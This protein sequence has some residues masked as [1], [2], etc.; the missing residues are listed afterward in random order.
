[1]RN[2][3]RWV[4]EETFRTI[5]EHAPIVSV[6]L[7]VRHD[8]GLL[9]GKRTNEPAK[10]EWFAPGGTVFKNETRQDAVH[11]IAE[12]ELGT[13]VRIE[14]ELGTYEHLYDTSGFDDINSK[15]Y[16]ATAYV[17]TPLEDRFEPDDQHASLETFT[18]PFPDLHRYM[19]R[20]L[21]DLEAREGLF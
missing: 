10:G 9:L 12:T 13:E 16:L 5:V 4:P 20:Y 14:T 7:L 19:E 18:E 17:V 2:D 1:M 3:P 21:D 15:H 11:R 8:D 6:D